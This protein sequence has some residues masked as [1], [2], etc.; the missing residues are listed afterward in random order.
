MGLVLVASA[1]VVKHWS[2]VA[3]EGGFYLVCIS[4]WQ[5]VIE[6]SQ[7]RHSRWNLEAR[8]EVEI[9]EDG[10]VLARSQVP[11]ELSFL[12]SIGTTSQGCCY[13]QKA[14]YPCTSWQSEK[15]LQF[16]P[17]SESDGGNS[18]FEVPSSWV[19][20]VDDKTN[21]DISFHITLTLKCIMLEHNLSLL[22]CVPTCHIN[23]TT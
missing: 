6:G 8:T 15:C 2:E 9:I 17:I 21:Q 22:V 23:N 18:L 1:A 3:W 11:V 5:S 14:G 10:C 12:Y 13:P 20:Q 16:I 4:T 7:S 19:C